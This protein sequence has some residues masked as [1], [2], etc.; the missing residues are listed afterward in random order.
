MSTRPNPDP[1]PPPI[2][3]QGESA[4]VMHLTACFAVGGLD[5]LIHKRRPG[6]RIAGESEAG[7]N[8]GIN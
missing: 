3:N 1:S 5:D 6:G 4:T 7:A 2:I 8:P